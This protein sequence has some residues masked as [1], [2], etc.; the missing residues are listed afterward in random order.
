[1]R[2]M[3]NTEAG[4]KFQLILSPEKGFHVAGLLY[5]KII[6]RGKKSMIERQWCVALMVSL[7]HNPES[8]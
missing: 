5:L 2:L 8:V 6:C 3:K 1:M 7:E 4:I